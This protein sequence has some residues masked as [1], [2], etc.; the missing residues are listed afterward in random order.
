MVSPIAKRL[1]ALAIASLALLAP[2]PAAACVQCNGGD[3]TITALGVEQPY[4]HRVRVALDERVSSHRMG[5]DVQMQ[6]TLLRSTLHVVYAPHGR[7]LLS[8][9]LPWISAWSAHTGM[10]F[11]HLSTVNGL[12]DLELTGRV[13]VYRDRKFAPQH[14]VALT[15]GVKTPTGPRLKDEAGYWLSEDQQ[16]GS[17]S[18]DPIVGLSYAWLSGGLVST[19]VATSYRHGTPGRKGEQRG[20]VFVGQAQV[21]LQPLQRLAIAGSLDVQHRLP[22][23]FGSGQLQPD[24]GGTS[25]WLSPSL[26]I[27]PAASWV[28]RLGAS[29]P[30]HTW[31]RG[32]QHEAPQGQLALAWDIR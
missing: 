3:P 27:V 16:P 26:L 23:R 17:G 29:I 31:L 21:Q 25:L 18:W 6:T 11:R 7:V 13:I 1:V 19:L 32:A 22:D 14:L 28:I 8:A 20:G 2:R 15:A 5:E 10:G 12:G 30:L 24:T 9:A 4:R